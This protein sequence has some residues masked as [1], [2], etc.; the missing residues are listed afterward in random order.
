MNN[1]EE[2]NSKKS[3]IIILVICVLFL[4]LI[5]KAYTYLPDSSENSR[6]AAQN[7]IEQTESSFQSSDEDAAES[8]EENDNKQEENSKNLKVSLPAPDKIT[9][10]E[11]QS[12]A[13]K[14]ENELSSIETELPNTE[15]KQQELSPEEQAEQILIQGDKY[16]KDKQYVKALEEYNKI[17]SITKDT[18]YVAKSYEEI[19]T[20]YAIVKRYGTALSF[21]QKAYNMSPTSSREMLLARLYYKTGDIDKATQRINNVLRRDFAADR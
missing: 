10:I 14:V 20:I 9:E 13:T 21:A 18:Y 12:E 11:D 19:A 17:F 2:F 8:Q 3:L 16:K 6:I 4:V 7:N 5:I 15:E 1:Y